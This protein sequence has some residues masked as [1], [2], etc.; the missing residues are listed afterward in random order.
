MTAALATLT[1]LTA[2]WMLVV[3][4]ARIVEQSGPRIAAALKGRS[5]E[6]A[7]TTV[8]MRLRHRERGSHA[9]RATPRLRAAA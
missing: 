9:F 3:I 2:I 6:P 1:F 7:L 5:Q 4:G 8:P